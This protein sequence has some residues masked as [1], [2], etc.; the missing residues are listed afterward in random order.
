MGTK[1]SSVRFS[2]PW[3]YDW[4]GLKTSGY[5]PLVFNSSRTG[6]ELPRH[7]SLIQMGSNAT[8]ALTAFSESITQNVPGQMIG[9]DKSQVT[10]KQAVATSRFF[11]PSKPSELIDPSLSNAAVARA[12]SK[13]YGKIR[14]L[15]S[16]L[17]GQVF[18]GELKE[19]INLLRHPIEKSV[20]LTEALIIKRNKL[21]NVPKAAADSWLEYRFGILPLISDINQIISLASDIADKEAHLSY[22]CYGK[23]ESTSVSVTSD[24]LPAI[25]GFTM[26]TRVEEVRR[27]E[28]IIRFGVLASHLDKHETF[29]SRIVASLD[30]LSSVPITAWELI[31]YSFLVD[32]FVN[33]GDLIT[34]AVTGTSALS[35]T[36]RSIIRSRIVTTQCFTVDG[37]GS[38]WVVDKTK[39]IP[40]TFVAQRRDVQR[41]GTQLGIP[42]VVFSL[43]GSNIRYLNIA[44]LLASFK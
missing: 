16:P 14:E 12:T 37:I 30:D 35:Y 10:G 25:F 40:K 33:V 23:A 18:L 19:T 6:V 9:V 26:G 5:F 21:K 11:L 42:P 20:R 24:P 29:S 44:A 1:T 15:Q 32:Y 3:S 17:N 28:C 38:N 2:D 43:P 4:K 31:P 22:R 13:A 41:D 27:Y 8:T 39:F 7:R 34:A 36:S